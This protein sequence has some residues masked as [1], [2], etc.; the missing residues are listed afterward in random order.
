[1]T[2][3]R[4]LLKKVRFVTAHGNVKY[5]TIHAADWKH[6]L[7]KIEQRMEDRGYS[8]YVICRWG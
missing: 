4:K 3:A 1:M 6:L 2:R 8:S 5:A 7:K